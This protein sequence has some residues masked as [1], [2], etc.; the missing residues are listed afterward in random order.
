MKLFSDFGTSMQYVWQPGPSGGAVWHLL[1]LFFS[2]QQGLFSYFCRQ[3]LS[4]LLCF[5]CLAMRCD[6]RHHFTPCPCQALG[7]CAL[8]VCA[9]LPKLFLP[10]MSCTA[11]LV[12]DFPR[13]LCVH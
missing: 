9:N 13:F 8:V 2:E 1:H 12:S 5:A 6:M 4:F 3:N 10:L 7:E 11:S